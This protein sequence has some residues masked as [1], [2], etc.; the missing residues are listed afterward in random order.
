MMRNMFDHAKVLLTQHDSYGQQQ[1]E[2]P[3]PAQV[4]AA[5]VGHGAKDGGEE[6]AHQR[7]QAPDQGHVLVVDS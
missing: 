7:G 5:A 3:P 4:G 2:R 6:E 1:Y